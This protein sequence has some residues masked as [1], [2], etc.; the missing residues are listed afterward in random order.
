LAWM[1][2]MFLAWMPETR[3]QAKEQPGLLASEA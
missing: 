3:P 2:E 1:P